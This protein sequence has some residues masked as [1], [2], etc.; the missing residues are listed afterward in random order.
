MR[1]DNQGENPYRLT[2]ECSP[3]RQVL[4]LSKCSRC[5]MLLPSVSRIA[6]FF[7]STRAASIPSSRPVAL[8]G[9]ARSGS[10]GWPLLRPPEGLVLD[11]REHD[12]S[13]VWFGTW[14]RSWGYM[15]ARAVSLG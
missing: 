7:C 10:Q 11:G 4:P 12:G 13:L 8:T 15:L 3:E 5:L 14:R 1:R 9:H 2:Q 6:P